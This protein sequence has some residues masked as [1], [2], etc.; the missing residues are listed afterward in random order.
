MAATFTWTIN[1]MTCSRQAEGETDV[2][3][4][5]NWACFGLD[6]GY[7]SS[8]GGTQSFTYKAGAPFTPYSDL[9]QDQVLGWV[10]S[11]GV[12]KSAVEAAVQLA[13][14]L[15]ANPPVITPPLPWVPE[16]ELPPVPG[17]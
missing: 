5:A 8:A 13:I 6:G 12:D 10:W 4:S 7:S 14:D 15:N 9:T 16:P 1:Q 3:I 2:V 11:S 17:A